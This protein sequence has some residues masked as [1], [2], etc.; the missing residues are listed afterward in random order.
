MQ[1]IYFLKGQVQHYSWGGHSFIP[2]LLNVGNTNNQPFAEYWLG[3]HPNFS[4][5]IKRDGD[6]VPLN[7]FIEEQSHQVLGKT[8]AERFKSLPFLLKVLDVGQ[9]LSIQVHPSLT[10]AKKGY[11]QENNAGISITAAHRNYKDANHK[12]EQMIALGDFWLLHG[13][14]P[15]NELA[16]KLESVPELRFLAGIAAAEGYSKLY[17]RVM[18]M[19]KEELQTVLQP[20]ADRIVPLYKM[21]QLEKNSEDFWAAR[22]IETFCTHGNFDKGLFSIYF[23]NLVHLKKGEAIFQPAGMPHAYLEGQNIEVMANSDNVL[24]GGLTTKFVDVAELMKHTAFVATHPNILQPDEK[25]LY[26]T[27]A[28]EFALY[29][30]QDQHLRLESTAASAEIFLVLSGLVEVST[31]AENVNLATGEAAFI[32]AGTDFKLESNG[33]AQVYRAAVP[34]A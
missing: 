24:R 17:E 4:S 15:M 22:A 25:G 18:L 27:P 28:A 10:E 16:A 5:V 23:F 12:P 14:K 32:T 2:Q 1:R 20:L 30:Y 9:M 13:F 6:D 29:Q 7:I 8:V 3:A 21:G 31:T 11:E 34:G 19:E 33:A 26:K